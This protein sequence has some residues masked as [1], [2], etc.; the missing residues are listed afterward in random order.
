MKLNEYVT[1]HE[2]S[3]KKNRDKH[4]R[5]IS[6]IILCVYDYINKWTKD[7][8]SNEQKWINIQINHVYT[9]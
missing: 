5:L 9:N 2:W 4:D 8:I 6:I 7:K 1:M 3:Y